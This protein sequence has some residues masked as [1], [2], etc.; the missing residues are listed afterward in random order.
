[1]EK[2]RMCCQHMITHLLQRAPRRRLLCVH[3]CLNGHRPYTL[4]LWT[5]TADHLTTLST[6]PSR[7]SVLPVMG[8]CRHPD[9]LQGTVVEGAVPPAAS[10]GLVYAP[11]R[12]TVSIDAEER[13]FEGSE[14][15]GMP[16][17]LKITHHLTRTRRCAN[18][19]G[20]GPGQARPPHRCFWHCGP[21]HF[22][23]Y[24]RMRSA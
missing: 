12:L 14:N 3:V 13:E 15:T 17:S 23:G 8:L 2:A 18:G 22:L 10:T 21:Q 24:D 9:L 20:D 16:L 1:M 4:A 19:R 11:T 7:I 6:P 5:A